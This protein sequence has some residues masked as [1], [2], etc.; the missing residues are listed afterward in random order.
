LPE[1]W[2]GTVFQVDLEVVGTM[3]RKAV[4]PF[5]AEYISVLVI[6]LGYA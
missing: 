1:G 6:F 5:L 2:L 4:C 3:V